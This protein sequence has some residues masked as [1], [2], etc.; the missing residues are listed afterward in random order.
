M[1]T[2]DTC[3][4][5][6]QLPYPTGASRPCDYDETSCEFAEAVEAQLDLL[7]AVVQRTETTV[8]MAW[9]RTSL[10]FS[11]VQNAAQN[12]VY[13]PP[14]DTVVVDTNDM[15]D[16]VRFNGITV[17]TPGLYLIWV[18]VRGTCTA[19]TGTDTNNSYSIFL[20][21][22]GALSN[23]WFPLIRF[24]QVV[25]NQVQ[26]QGDLTVLLLP[27]DTQVGFTITPIAQP[28]DTMLYTDVEMALT[29][30]GDAP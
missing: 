2:G 28:G 25:V 23:N 8:P 13:E 17:N 4:P 20:D 27:A 19:V 15:V 11:T 5:I 18:Y 26:R 22:P 10:A 16:L 30:V 24:T 3:T 7:D 14:F 12:A 29:W 6:Y 1:P 9:I 21:P